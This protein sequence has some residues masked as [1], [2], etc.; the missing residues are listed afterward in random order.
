[1]RHTKKNRLTGK[2]K[3]IITAIVI[4]WGLLGTVSAMAEKLPNLT[5]FPAADLVIEPQEDGSI[6]LRFTTLSW[7]KGS[8]P[9]E[10]LGGNVDKVNGKQ[11]VFQRIYSSPNSYRDVM[12]GSFEW[13]ETHNHFH[14]DNYAIYTLQ[15][16]TANGASKRIGAKTTFCIMDTTLINHRLKGASKRPVYNACDLSVQGMSVGWGDEYH[17]SLDGQSL[18]ISGLPDG[19][20]NLEIEIDPKNRIIESD[21]TDNISTVLIRIADGVVSAQTVIPTAS[22]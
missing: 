16:V 14:F 6:F 11:E 20:Y 19:D 8:G 5:P 18:D 10:L 9:L 22:Q 13:H 1:M 15:P 17:Y 7:N 4:S 21:E 12:A 3:V 2:I